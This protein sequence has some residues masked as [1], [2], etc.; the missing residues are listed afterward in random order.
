M[1]VQGGDLL[2]RSNAGRP[3]VVVMGV[4]W[5][6]CG[7]RAFVRLRYAPAAA[8]TVFLFLVF[9]LLGA[10]SSWKTSTA[11]MCCSWHWEKPAL[12][13]CCFVDWMICSTTDSDNDSAP[14]ESARSTFPLHA[15]HFWDHDGAQDAETQRRLLGPGSRYGLHRGEIRQ[16]AG[17][18]ERRCCGVTGPV[19]RG[20]QRH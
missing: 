11:S 16:E 14:Q 13:P 5:D 15:L 10:S 20:Q 19:S 1:A 2:K 18:R 12:F 17:G 6:C 7:Y 3:Q 4:K 9:Y 8:G